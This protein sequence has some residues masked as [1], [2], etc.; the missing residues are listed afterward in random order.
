MYEKRDEGHSVDYWIE[1]GIVRFFFPRK[2]LFCV[3]YFVNLFLFQ[4][5]L[6]L[7]LKLVEMSGSNRSALLKFC[8]FLKIFIFVK[9]SYL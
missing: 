1:G 9:M 4:I 5:Y 3:H 7:E 2:F 6:E 8:Q